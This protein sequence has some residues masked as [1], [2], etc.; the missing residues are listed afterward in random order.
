MLNK[1]RLAPYLLL[2]ALIGCFTPPPTYRE[3]NAPDKSFS[4]VW[5]G[6]QLV[7]RRLGYRADREET[8]RGRRVFQS[9]W[10]TSLRWPRNS[11][12][13]RMR[14]EVVRISPGQPGWRV[15]CYVEKQI[16]DSVT[17]SLNREDDDWEPAGQDP[18]YENRLVGT[19]R[20]ELGLPVLEPTSRPVSEAPARNR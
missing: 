17:G 16:V 11:V 8:D 19:L 13:R 14:A 2:L 1:T 15:R 3:I 18:K 10:N 9:T 6:L 5:I 7:T 20:A 4:D 12:R